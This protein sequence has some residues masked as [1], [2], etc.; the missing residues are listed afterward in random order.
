[1]KSVAEWSEAKPNLPFTNP[2]GGTVGVSALQTPKSR[3][4]LASNPNH[5]THLKRS[6]DF[7]MEIAAKLSIQE[8]Q[9]FEQLQKLGEQNDILNEK[10][11]WK[12]SQIETLEKQ[13]KQTKTADLKPTIDSQ[14]Y[15]YAIS[16]CQSNWEQMCQI[17]QMASSQLRSIQDQFQVSS[18]ASLVSSLNQVAQH[19]Y[20]TIL[21][22]KKKKRK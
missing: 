4:S 13:L 8:A 20:I 5:T 3:T 7:E 9:F 21:K 19:F 15:R 12:D 17:V 16:Q 11:R 14:G 22:S 2:T 1:R 18:L 10:I 6:T